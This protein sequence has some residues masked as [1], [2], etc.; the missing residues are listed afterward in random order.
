MAANDGNG[1]P[2][3]GDDRAARCHW[4]LL[5]LAGYV[6]DEMLTRCRQW[7]A[8]GRLSEIAATV[9]HVAT[10]SGVKMTAGDVAL[11]A[12][13]NRAAGI[14]T[15]HH[16]RIATS[17]VAYMPAFE[18]ADERPTAAAGSDP[19]AAGTS[20]AAT[21]AVRRAVAAEPSVRVAWS[22]WRFA[23]NNAPWPPPRQVF[24]VETEPD[25]DLPAVTA[26]LQQ[27]LLAAGEANPQVEVY[28][29]RREPP[30]YQQFA[31]SGGAMLYT[32]DPRPEIQLAR[33]F[34]RADETGPEFDPDHPTLDGEE[35]VL[36]LNYLSSG[37]LLMETTA[38]MEDILAPDDGQVVPMS[39]RTDG[40]WVWSDATWYYLNRHRLAPEPAFLE[41]IR[42]REY[43]F[44]PVDALDVNRALA[45]LQEPA[46]SDPVWVA[47]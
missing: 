4:M 9:T 22:S 34:D 41:H 25:A 1:H 38:Q 36:V 45:V 43:D 27:T 19:G 16:T 6:P 10:A 42:N 47:R 21:D 5:R 24:V 14:T 37:E 7:L 44:E 35:R 13:V 23:D 33:V 18:F 31:R 29:T 28:P 3:D 2:V 12:E 11:L 32:R 39:F 20:D 26:G 46:E 30:A 15:L 17:E 8:E 40:Y